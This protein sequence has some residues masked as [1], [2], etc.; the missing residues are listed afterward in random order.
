MALRGSPG[1]ERGP[2]NGHSQAGPGRRRSALRSLV[3]GDDCGRDAA[4]LVHLLSRGLGPCADLGAAFAAGGVALL[5]L[6]AAAAALGR[7][8][9]GR[10]DVGS[11]GVAQ[12]GGVAGAEVD[13]VRG[14]VNP[15]R[16]GLL[17]LAAV[18]IVEE[19]H[20]NL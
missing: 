16:N 11:E 5:A 1:S 15:E 20:L 18:Q 13:F 9:A 12:L 14:T 4:A 8:L 19:E 3:L 7:G 10:L 6:A 17:G 2:R